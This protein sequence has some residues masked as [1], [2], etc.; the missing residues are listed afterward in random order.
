MG[1]VQTPMPMRYD[2]SFSPDLAS[3]AMILP[4]TSPAK[5]RLL[6]VARTPPNIRWSLGYCQAIL[7]VLTSM[8]D[9]LPELGIIWDSSALRSASVGMALPNCWPTS[10]VPGT[11]GFD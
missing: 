7:P 8:A 9:R 10:G 1:G 2:Q 3:K 5:T 11:Q 6:A 4:F